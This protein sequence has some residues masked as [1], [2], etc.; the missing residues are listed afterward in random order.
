MSHASAGGGQSGALPGG[1]GGGF[2]GPGLRAATTIPAWP[3]RPPSRRPTRP[4]AY[5]SARTGRGPRFRWGG[6][7]AGKASLGPSAPYRLRL[8]ARRE[9]NKR[10]PLPAGAGHCATSS[11]SDGRSTGKW[12]SLAS[13]AC[14]AL[15]PHP[16]GLRAVAPRLPASARR[17]PEPFTAQAP[18][19]GPAPGGESEPVRGGRPTTRGHVT[20]RAPA[21]QI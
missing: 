19:G 14:P 17:T 1:G 10:A 18:Q 8:E 7:G 15:R 3:P 11:G 9:R 13:L 6:G 4:A 21:P 20:P 12:V 2:P 5:L 16:S